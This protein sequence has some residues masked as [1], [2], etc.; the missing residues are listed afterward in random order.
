MRLLRF[1]HVLGKPDRGVEG[2]VEKYL[3]IGVETETITAA[4]DEFASLA[5]SEKLEPLLQLLFGHPLWSVAE[6]RRLA[7]W[8]RSSTR[9]RRPERPRF[10][11]RLSGSF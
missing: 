1:L 10:I 6:I 3:K 2:I 8:L 9:Q 4:E 7:W 11:S 5:N